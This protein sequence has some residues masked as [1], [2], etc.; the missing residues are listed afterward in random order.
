M[1]NGGP[2]THESLHGGKAVGTCCSYRVEIPRCHPIRAAKR[3]CRSRNVEAE[4][5]THL[6]TGN[7]GQNRMTHCDV[8]CPQVGE[9]VFDQ[10][11]VIHDLKD[12]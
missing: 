9:G 6:A 12:K 11:E 4:H 5:A 10:S 7:R 1:E 3:D 2:T 8:H